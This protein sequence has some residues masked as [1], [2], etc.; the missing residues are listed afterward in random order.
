MQETIVILV[1]ILCFYEFPIRTQ[2]K[3]SSFSTGV[4][5]HGVNRYLEETKISLVNKLYF[6]FHEV[7][8]SQ[9][10]SIPQ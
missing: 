7:Y 5:M 4:D 6:S 1:F 2:C 3:V 10:K 8:Q 9:V